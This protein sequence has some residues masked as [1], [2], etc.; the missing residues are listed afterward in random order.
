MRRVPL[1]LTIVP[2]ALGGA[3]YWHYWSGWKDQFRTDIATVMPDGVT[4][5]GRSPY[6]VQAIGGFPYRLEAEVTNPFYELGGAHDERRPDDGP[7]GLVLSA[8]RALLNRNP[9]QRDL[10]IVRAG[11]PLFVAGVTGLV[12]ADVHGSATQS[13]SSIHL[14]GTG[15]ARLSTVFKGLKATTALFA[16][17][18]TADHF[19][20]H[21]RETRARSNEAW[22][23]TPP[24]QAQVVLSGTGVRIGQG[25]PLTL[26]ADFGVTATSRLRD[27]AGWAAGGTVEVHSLTLADASGEVLA[28]TASGVPAEGTIRLTG[29]ITTVCP[30]SV[31]AAFA[32]SRAPVEQRLR[33]PVRLAF[34]GVP[35]AF[36]VG[37]PPPSAPTAFRAQLPPCPLL[38]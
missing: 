16:A 7:V 2:L 8:K 24:Q 30:A 35:G 29:T 36:T 31:A 20:V 14:N 15:I 38:R 25:A 18:V 28:M 5:F 13:V 26:A 1:W 9:W 33:N 19:E 6:H 10:T 22:S 3:V 32:A 21:L 11:H 37:A 4:G 23:P 12:G 27:Y 17:P 34:G